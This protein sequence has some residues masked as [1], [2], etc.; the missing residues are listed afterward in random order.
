VFRIL[1][2]SWFNIVEGQNNSHNFH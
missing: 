1:E 2:A